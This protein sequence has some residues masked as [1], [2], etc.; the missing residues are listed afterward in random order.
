MQP[1]LFTCLLDDEHSKVYICC[2]I[3]CL[4][5][6]YLQANVEVAHHVNFVRENWLLLTHSF[7]ILAGFKISYKYSVIGITLYRR[8]LMRPFGI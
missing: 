5:Q 7:R 3:C 4:R 1:N 6:T 2:I 8:F